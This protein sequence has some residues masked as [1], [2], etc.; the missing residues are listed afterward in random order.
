[1]QAFKPGDRVRDKKLG[2]SGVIQYVYEQPDGTLID[3]LWD[4][5][6]SEHLGT[7]RIVLEPKQKRYKLAGVEILRPIFENYI[8]AAAEAREAHSSDNPQVRKLA[9]DLLT[10][11]GK[12]KVAVNSLWG[13]RGTT[14]QSEGV[15]RLSPLLQS[16]ADVAMS[17]STAVAASDG[18]YEA[19]D[20]ILQDAARD[21]SQL[22]KQISSLEK[23]AQEDQEDL[24]SLRD[25]LDAV[26]ELYWEANEET[27]EELKPK[28][29][30]VQG[31]VSEIILSGLPH[32]ME[33]ADL[34]LSKIAERLRVLKG[35]PVEA[36]KEAL[37][38]AIDELEA[39]A[40]SLASLSTA[41][42]EELQIVDQQYL[43]GKLLLTVTGPVSDLTEEKIKEMLDYAEADVSL[44]PLFTLNGKTA[45]YVTIAVAEPAL[46]QGEAS[47][48]ELEE[49]PKTDEETVTA[50]ER[51]TT[52]LGP[53]TARDVP[54]APFTQPS[55]P[56][57][58]NS[59]N[60]GDFLVATTEGV[61]RVVKKTKEGRLMVE[62]NDT[63]FEFWPEEVKQVTAK[64]SRERARVSGLVPGQRVFVLDRPYI[65]GVIRKTAKGE[66]AVVWDDGEV[67]TLDELRKSKIQIVAL[68]QVDLEEIW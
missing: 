20:I 53:P 9:E 37:E 19:L 60:Q 67:M 26:N 30:K 8:A 34:A 28:V 64:Q 50:E 3:V 33:L 14:A 17:L 52:V 18:D 5:G 11:L 40:S 57:G 46:P 6:N 43:P 15:S 45:V 56:S 42:E 66:L 36:Q 51:E 58:P 63:L 49:E 38:K 31:L 48:E 47:E 21:L 39:I 25:F 68:D 7:E 65:S 1:M 35:A 55:G 4:D 24:A 10:I 32:E 27:I 44:S 29:Q 41:Q 23:T 54:T 12:V 61:G 2:R 59:G 62:I 16:L 13:L 22:R